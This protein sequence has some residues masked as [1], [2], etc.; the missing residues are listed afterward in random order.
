MTLNPRPPFF[1]RLFGPGT[2]EACCQKAAWDA[3]KVA[4]KAQRHA[5]RIAWKAERDARRAAWKAQ[6]HT[7]RWQYHG[8][9]AELWGLMW[10]IFWVGFALLLIISPEFR[11]RVF[12]F[13]ITLPQLVVHVLYSIAGRSEI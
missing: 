2:T 12:H 10:A 6:A 11:S 7:A 1:D 3:Q 5:Q 13:V 4:W 8:P 9:F